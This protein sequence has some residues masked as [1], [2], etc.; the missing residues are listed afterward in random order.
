MKKLANK[1]IDVNPWM[2][3]LIEFYQEEMGSDESSSGSG[4]SASGSGS[5]RSNSLSSVAGIS[6]SGA[7][8]SLS[9]L[10]DGGNIPNEGRLSS[11]HSSMSKQK[12]SKSNLEQPSGLPES[13]DS[14]ATMN[15]TQDQLNSDRP[16]TMI[17]D[18]KLT[19]SIETSER[20]SRSK[21]DK[22]SKKQPKILIDEN[23][24]LDDEDNGIIEGSIGSSE[25]KEKKANK[26]KSKK[27]SKKKHRDIQDSFDD[28][29]SSLL[30]ESSIG[31]VGS[32]G[33]KGKK[34]KRAQKMASELEE[35]LKK[36]N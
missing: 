17:I 33:K 36:I 18:S 28:G 5:S 16:D 35:T 34:G 12:Q 31:S 22:K 25:M 21:K 3:K 8:A 15:K 30:I 4:S 2:K 14:I 6:G 7:S 19:P 32:K 13:G 27:K 24:E 20:R 11:L 10:D 1:Q 29:Q 26:K 23:L 9:L